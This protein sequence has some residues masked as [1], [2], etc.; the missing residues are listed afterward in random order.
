MIGLKYPDIEFKE[1]KSNFLEGKIISSF[2]NLLRQ[3]E[4]KL[5]YLENEI[6]VTKI[7]SFFTARNLYL[8]YKNV[9][10]DDSKIK[11]Y[12]D[13]INWLVIHKSNQL[14][15]I[16]SD[17]YLACKYVKMKLQKNLCPHRIGVYDQVDEINFEKIIKKGNVILKISNGNGDNIFIHKNISSKEIE[18]IKNSTIFHFNRNYAL[19]VPSI[20]HLYTKKRIILE[21]MFLPLTDLYEFKIFLF[22]RKIKLINIINFIDGKKRYNLYDENF[23]PVKNQSEIDSPKK[24]FDEKILKKL[25][26]YAFKLS[27]DFPNFIRVDLYI[28]HKKIFLSELTFD[29]HDGLPKF[30]NLKKFNE[31]IKKWKRIDN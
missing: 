19:H 5:I 18:K 1:I 20:F 2:L 16:A 14:K 12:H 4:I 9:T 13:I 23:N 7:I 27:E 22:N 31:E 29:S 21:N 25:K 17:K 8:K 11:E 3:M 24:K 10:Y 30:Q 15:G 6:N 28:F 26:E